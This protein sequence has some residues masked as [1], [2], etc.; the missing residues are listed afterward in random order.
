MTTAKIS[1]KGHVA[2]P[3][4]V[5]DRL[6]LKAGT[7]VMIDVEGETL[8]MKRVRKLPDWRTMRGMAKGGGSLTKALEEERAA[9]N[10]HYDARI[11][12]GR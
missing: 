10:A 9:E 7:E 1:S 11:R 12:Q 3:K 4:A 6:N 2:I 5:R 8:V